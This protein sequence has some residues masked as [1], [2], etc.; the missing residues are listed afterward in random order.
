MSHR[1]CYWSPSYQQPEP[2][3]LSEIDNTKYHDIDD[4]PKHRKLKARDYIKDNQPELAELMQTKEFKSFK[5]EMN[6]VFGAKQVI[7]YD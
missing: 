6:N 1:V 3:V 7:S 5:N 2:L 4:L